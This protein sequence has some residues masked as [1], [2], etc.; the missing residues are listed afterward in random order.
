M[1]RK[2]LIAVLDFSVNLRGERLLFQKPAEHLQY[3]M[4]LRQ[5]T[6]PSGLRKYSRT[7]VI[8]TLAN[9]EKKTYPIFKKNVSLAIDDQL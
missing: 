8:H 2:R 1:Q 4:L 9:S 7:C 5:E 3:R 6:N